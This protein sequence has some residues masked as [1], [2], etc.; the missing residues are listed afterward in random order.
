MLLVVPSLNVA[1]AT[2]CSDAL[3][4]MLT[5]AGVT[6]TEVT[7]FV[8]DWTVRAAEPLIPSSEAV[9]VADPAALAV[10]NPALLADPIDAGLSVHAAVEPTLAVE[11]SL[12]FAVAE[13]C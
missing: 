11:P 7:V 8:A 2:N 3:V 10:T 6:P 5:L 1:V 4:A 12:Y 9:T 13:N